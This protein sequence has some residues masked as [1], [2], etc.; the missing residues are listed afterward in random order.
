MS[1]LIKLAVLSEVY[2]YA[3]SMSDSQVSSFILDLLMLHSLD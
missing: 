1:Q 3:L 2:L